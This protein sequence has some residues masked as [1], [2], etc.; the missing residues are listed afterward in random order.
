ME[1]VA[2]AVIV[3]C[4]AIYTGYS[5]AGLYGIGIAGVGGPNSACPHDDFWGKVYHFWDR[6]Y[7]MGGTDWFDIPNYHFVN[8]SLAKDLGT[9]TFANEMRHYGKDVPFVITELQLAGNLAL[10]IKQTRCLRKY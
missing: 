8:F 4:V 3:I 9:R 6:V 5:F 10:N 1:A 2:F 7:E